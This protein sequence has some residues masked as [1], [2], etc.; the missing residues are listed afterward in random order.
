MAR[1]ENFLGIKPRAARPARP[2]NVTLACTVGLVHAIVAIAL[3]VISVVIRTPLALPDP[4]R[5]IMNIP[6][7]SEVWA[8]VATLVVLP[9]LWVL[10][11]KGSRHARAI[12]VVVL[13]VRAALAGLVLHTASVGSVGWWISGL[14]VLD[15][16]GVILLFG[17]HRTSTFFAAARTALPRPPGDYG[18]DEPAL[19]IGAL[20]VGIAL[21]TGSAFLPLALLVIVTILGML[22]CLWAC[23]YLYASQHSKFVVWQDVLSRLPAAGVVVDVACGR[24]IAA[25]SSLREWPQATGVAADT[26]ERRHQSGNSPGATARNAEAAGVA[27]RLTIHKC[28]LSDVPVAESSADLVTCLLGLH[29]RPSGS[30][31]AEVVAEL[32]RIGRPGGFIVV[33]DRMPLDEVR[34]QFLAAG[35]QVLED[36]NAGP[37]SWYGWPRWALRVLVVRVA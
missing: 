15:V 23:I 3:T 28:S 17:G 1:E 32:L 14:V 35:A 21:L 16:V 30:A 37:R 34:E 12:I 2:W 11:L 19:P 29:R 18:L 8:L 13:F 5:P 26:Y 25:V 36:R 10:V 27:D 22:V 31:R 24:G 4:I 9:F 6:V 33:I 20:A 7:L